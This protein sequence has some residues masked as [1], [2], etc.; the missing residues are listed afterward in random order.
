MSSLI[1]I[2]KRFDELLLEKNKK[3]EKITQKTKKHEI[4]ERINIKLIELEIKT[5]SEKLKTTIMKKGLR[6][7]LMS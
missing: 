3:L 6:I 4:I 5:K 2:E 1:K 7:K